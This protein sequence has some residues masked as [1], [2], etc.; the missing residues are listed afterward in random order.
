MTRI[1]EEMACRSLSTYSR[2]AAQLCSCDF[3]GYFISIP[4]NKH[5]IKTREAAQVAAASFS[6]LVAFNKNIICFLKLILWV[7]NTT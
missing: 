5:Q 1:E 6:L 4:P 3:C 2:E 7:T